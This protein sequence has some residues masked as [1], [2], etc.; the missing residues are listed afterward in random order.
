MLPK[1]PTKLWSD[2]LVSSCGVGSVH[3]YTYGTRTAVPFISERQ[4]TDLPMHIGATFPNLQPIPN[5]GAW[6]GS[7]CKSSESCP[8][9]HYN[10]FF[11]TMIITPLPYRSAHSF[12]NI[13]QV[14]GHLCGSRALAKPPDCIRKLRQ[15]SK[16]VPG[17]S[18]APVR[19][20]GFVE[21]IYSHP[22]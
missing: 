20:R 8:V 16:L 18:L 1:S 5:L 22:C 19:T 2:A 9:N 12:R 21:C 15:K 11:F 3:R 6:H 13:Q 17:A 4:R 7:E 10:E 14:D